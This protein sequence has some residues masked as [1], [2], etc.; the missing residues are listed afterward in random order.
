MSLQRLTAVFLSAAIA[1]AALAHCAALAAPQKPAPP[2][3]AQTSSRKPADIARA[4]AY[5]MRVADR[6]CMGIVYDP[7]PMSKLI[8]KKGLTPIQI[9]EKYFSAFQAGYD[10]AGAH[11]AAQG[12]PSYCDFVLSSFVSKPRDYPGLKVP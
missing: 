4:M 7:A 2:A 10:E 12:L 5:L 1:I 11:I 6:A 8:D 9:R 3:A